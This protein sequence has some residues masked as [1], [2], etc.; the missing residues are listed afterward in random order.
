[1]RIVY[2]HAFPLDGRMWPGGGPTLYGRGRTLEDWA[3]SLLD[4]FEGELAVIGS[5]MGGYT[6][7]EMARLAPERIGALALIGA[8]VDA[9]SDERR[10]GRAETIQLIRDRGPEGL[11][12]SMR[13]RAFAP[14]AP[15]DALDAAREI[16]LDQD[17]DRLV[18]AVE[19]IRD[20]R[21]NT[22]TWRSFPGRRHAYIGELDSFV[23][24]DEVE[25]AHAIPNAG[26]MLSLEHPELLDRIA[27]EL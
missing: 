5:S 11:W 8:R 27:A 15:Q 14:H 2:L 4:E 13:E 20:R 9:D 17:P 23:S 3:R 22:D 25:G 19:A 12:E 6:A 24:P 1:V 18:E 16:A 26:H 21:D 10:A 7:L